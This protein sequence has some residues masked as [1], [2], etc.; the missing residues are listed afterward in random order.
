MKTT[1][2]GFMGW[3]VAGAAALGLAKTA[4][5]SPISK[6]A[7]RG[8]GA[9]KGF[10]WMEKPV[11]P[12]PLVATADVMCDDPNL[13]FAAGQ[14]AR[15]RTNDV[16]LNLRTREQMIVVGTLRDEVRLIRGAGH[17]FPYSVE[18]G[19]KFLIVGNAYSDPL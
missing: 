6:V 17:S 2:R 12:R 8:P 10:E 5:A 1:R 9:P 4:T 15:L 14:A 7:R 16:I 13:F 11:Y 3:L 19:D 18:T